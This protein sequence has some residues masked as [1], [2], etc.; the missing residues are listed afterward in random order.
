[1]TVLNLVDTWPRPTR[2][3]TF[4]AALRQVVGLLLLVAAVGWIATVLLR[5]MDPATLVLDPF[6]WWPERMLQR[7]AT[8][9]TGLLLG[10][11]GLTLLY[12]PSRV[13]LFLRRFGSHS[14]LVVSRAL[15]SLVGSQIRTVTLDDR[16]YPSL[17]VPLG[18]RV[19]LVSVALVVV[20]AAVVVSVFAADELKGVYALSSRQVARTI[21][22]WVAWTSAGVFVAWAHFTRIRRR[23]WLE[24][25][26]PRATSRLRYRMRGVA[27]SWRRSAF[28]AGQ[29][30]VVSVPDALWRKA[31]RVAMREADAVIVDLG[32]FSEHLLG[33]GTASGCWTSDPVCGRP[34]IRRVVDVRPSRDRA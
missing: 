15:M 26:V 3:L 21:A 7:L 31:V 12:R 14:N 8:L 1:M 34:R 28:M 16:Q 32:S 20:L 25:P 13:V 11:V 23:T 6:L 27:S 4:W 30:L 24:I 9:M 5:T 2:R 33:T 17:G 22:F 29:S 18:L 19:V 10:L